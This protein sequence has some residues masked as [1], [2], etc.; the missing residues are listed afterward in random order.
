M[1][2]E[3]ARRLR[4][5]VE[6]LD[7]Y[8]VARVTDPRRVERLLTELEVRLPIGRE[9]LSKLLQSVIALPRNVSAYRRAERALRWA[10]LIAKTN[11]AVLALAL[12]LYVLSLL[13][14]D[15]KLFMNSLLMILASFILINFSFLLRAYASTKLEAAYAE[16]LPELERLGGRIKVVVEYL[17]RQLKRELK[18][19][20]YSLESF[21]L[22]LWLSDY[23]GIVV[24]EKPSKLSS[25]YKV[26]LA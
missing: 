17:L 3:R 21:R 26:R 9:E 20:G 13:Y 18:A 6:A 7:S 15:A 19:R 5:L 10:A 16:K 11:L 24:V 8:R 1:S 25:R 14:E 4:E 23:A 2:L 22:K 12:T